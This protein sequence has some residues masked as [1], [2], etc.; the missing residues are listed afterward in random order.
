MPV[1]GALD[2]VKHGNVG[3]E[4]VANLHAQ[5]ALAADGLA[6]PIQLLVLVVEN[7][8]VVLMELL[9]VHLAGLL[10][11]PGRLGGFGVV[12]VGAE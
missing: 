8:G 7:L 1:G 10:T 11:V 3:V 6:Q 9:I 4:L 12:A 5:L 2:L